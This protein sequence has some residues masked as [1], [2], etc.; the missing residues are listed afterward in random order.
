MSSISS[1][2]SVNITSADGRA[3]SPAP[4]SPRQPRF[5]PSPATSPPTKGSG[6]LLNQLNARPK[7]VGGVEHQSIRTL[8]STNLTVG[9][10]SG[11]RPPGIEEEDE[12]RSQH[13][14]PQS[15][16]QRPSNAS[17][18]SLSSSVDAVDLASA[19][20]HRKTGTVRSL[21]AIRGPSA[22][23]HSDTES[24]AGSV[25]AIREGSDYPNSIARQSA[26]LPR[27]TTSETYDRFKDQAPSS[28]MPLTS[29][30]LVSGLPKNPSTWTLAD[31]D[32]VAGV[33]HSEGA[34]GRWWRAEVLGSTITPGVGG[35]KDK[36][37][38]R[39]VKNPSLRA[40]VSESAETKA[41]LVKGDLGKMLSKSLKL[42]FTREVE[43]IASTLQPAS[44]I[45]SFTF[46]IPSN[47]ELTA[48]ASN[49]N[50]RSSVFSQATA[51]TNMTGQTDMRNGMYSAAGGASGQ[52][53]AVPGGSHIGVNTAGLDIGAP[54]RG[55][56]RD[57]STSKEATYH[58]VCL[59]VWS[60]ADEERSAAIRR[61]L[62]TA[63]NANA[64]AT[65]GH[66]VSMSSMASSIGT[67][68]TERARKQSTPWS[69]MDESETDAGAM[70][71]SDADYMTGGPG[72]A[73]G[74]IGNE[75]GAGASTLFL[76]QNTVF[77][78]PYALTLV[79]RHP[80]YD[81]MRD[82]LTLSWA[83]FSK[84]VQSHTL[85]IAKILE[86]ASSRAGEIVRLDAGAQGEHLEVVCRF[87][88]GLDFGKGL[89]DVNFTMWPL[90]RCL[91]LDNILTLC[92][93]ALAPTGRVL[94]VSRH[95]A[96]LGIA[97]STLKYLVEL[98]GWSG[99][100]LH[101]VHAR[102][103]K[104]YL[105][106]PG[107]WIIAMST[108]ARYCV[109]PMP[110]VCVCDL[111]I[112]Y[113]N[114]PTPPVGAVSVKQQRDKF[115]KMLLGAFDQYFHPDHGVPSEFKE[116]FPAG[117][118][119]PLCK[120][121]S[122]RGSSIV[123]E[124]I[125]APT[126]WQQTRV[127]GAF[128]AVLKEKAKKPS[129]LKRIS[130]LG[131]TRRP[132]ELTNAEKMIQMSIRKRATAFVNARD[133]L[134][135]KIGRLS[136]RLNF[137]MTES[138]LWRQK[139]VAFEGYA[140]KLSTEAGE[141]RAKI[142]KEQRE[143][144]RLSGLVSV[145]AHE[146]HM[147]QTR[148]VETESK[149]K[150]AAVELERMRQEME[151]MEEEREKMVQEVEAQIERA[152]ASMTLTDNYESD[153]SGGSQYSGRGRFNR[154][155]S[156]ASIISRPST[157]G[158]NHS[159][160]NLTTTNSTVRLRSFA[161][162]S[163][164]AN[165]NQQDLSHPPSE[166][167]A[168]DET[169]VIQEE[170]AENGS[171]NSREAA[172]AA[173]PEVRKRKFSANSR[174]AHLDGLDAVDVGISQRI[175]NVAEKM[176]AIQQKLENAF[177]HQKNTRTRGMTT[178]RHSM[179]DDDEVER[180]RASRPPQTQKYMNV[181]TI[182]S[183]SL[184]AQSAAAEREAITARRAIT[185]NPTP[186]S[187]SHGYI[188][189]LPKLPNVHI[190]GDSQKTTPTNSRIRTTPPTPVHASKPVVSP[191]Q[192]SEAVQ[193]SNNSIRPSVASTTDDSDSYMSAYSHS[194]PRTI[195][196][197]PDVDEDDDNVDQVLGSGASIAE[198]L[199]QDHEVVRNGRDY[200]DSPL[201][202]P[203]AFRAR[204]ASDATASTTRLE[205]EAANALQNRFRMDTGSP[206]VSDFSTHST[207]ITRMTS[208][209][210]STESKS[211]HGHRVAT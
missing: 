157:A 99:V 183:R 122:K 34:V 4:S 115:R 33:H 37:K 128:D 142:N 53:L 170:D 195:H 185:P 118:F 67:T 77:W 91:N 58:G 165:D 1:S 166:D 159:I 174:E 201:I 136:R 98:R 199:L 21:D 16:Q 198:V 152:L 148:L 155:N 196:T 206:T 38:K 109:R 44:T 160:T 20:G 124:S 24:R 25:P 204:T 92:E 52:L 76:P 32:S 111:D 13:T 200:Q 40:G 9:G 161:T 7:P 143:S 36:K 86:A 18:L 106:D 126:W 45:H 187:K 132:A 5:T 14:Q 82:Y 94:F 172:A 71:E 88:G 28:N 51:Q 162:S 3:L 209:T 49:G 117:R 87:P 135:T 181:P 207:N 57:L 85:Q 101:N 141:L 108:E 61:T 96:M 107:P 48:P 97:V 203:S 208:P 69:E 191:K 74:R 8:S 46:S 84:D 70:T 2:P 54:A 151:E 182:R 103:A 168:H 193:A 190:N 83:R 202:T 72:A 90:F 154:A 10:S 26:T 184:S 63:A 60:H 145:T 171:V 156:R 110:E 104:I 167:L 114:C 113:V 121:V 205:M 27:P 188:P 62:E 29:L 17:M 177:E 163:T 144:K 140:E 116:A 78:L 129:L 95:P 189:P 158:S 123:A 119:R 192:S 133:D 35:S 75:D 146:K 39:G 6:W 11:L 73:N 134:E 175:D 19:D 131:M 47:R 55:S 137:L 149:H 127:I 105:E 138:D 125:K 59:M 65:R 173:P 211:W 22:R 150:Q 197:L 169:M 176:M 93:I 179:D 31:A 194:P 79:S 139:F 180:Q 42:S 120:I 112:N 130:T 23:P 147:L 164:L 66:K 43:I 41:G 50:F 89:V 64:R 15:S 153:Y 80:I 56:D 102:D 68:T 186:T 178:P 30:Y 81:L 100:A 12:V 210:I